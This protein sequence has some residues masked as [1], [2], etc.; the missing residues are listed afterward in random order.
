MTRL[1][2][3]AA[4]ACIGAL[5]GLFVFAVLALREP[6]Q[7]DAQLTCGH[8]RS[9]FSNVF[10]IGPTDCCLYNAVLS[11]QR[12][13]AY[14]ALMYLDEHEEYPAS[15]DALAKSKLMGIA[16][17][18]N[19]YPRY[20][21]SFVHAEDGL[22]ILASSS[23]HERVFVL[24]ADDKFKVLEGKFSGSAFNKASASTGGP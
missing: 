1:K 5:A 3:W 14:A 7:A 6:Q 13:I 16:I 9:W 8:G 23:N 2:R 24:F 22:Y 15:L 10:R 20:R 11:H 17:D 21:Y 4:A 18:E 19:E 12:H